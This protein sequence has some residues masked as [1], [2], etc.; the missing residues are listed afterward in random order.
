M[1]ELPSVIDARIPLPK[2][3]DFAKIGNSRIFLETEIAMNDT[4][5]LG[6]SFRQKIF[7][8]FS[9]VDIGELTILVFYR[10]F[11]HCNIFQI[12]VSFSFSC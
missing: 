8:S 2:I 5:I 6:G 3:I 12:F 4:K 11:A 9:F 10:I 7:S 1:F